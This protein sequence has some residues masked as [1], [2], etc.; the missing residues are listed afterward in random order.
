M[1]IT[2]T[3]FVHMCTSISSRI[4][5]FNLVMFPRGK[6]GGGHLSSSDLYSIFI[7]STSAS[8]LKG[9]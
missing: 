3:V 4:V 9:A 1:N 6:G 2:I 7:S 5:L 8:P